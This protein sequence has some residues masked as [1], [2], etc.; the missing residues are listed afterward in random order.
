[1]PDDRMDVTRHWLAHAPDGRW[2]SGPRVVPE[3]IANRYREMAGWTVEGPFVL[4]QHQGAVDL[5]RK[6][7]EMAGAKANGTDARAMAAKARAFVAALDHPG[8]Q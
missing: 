6:I 8:G 5:L 2:S 1:M 7:G 4:E 3:D